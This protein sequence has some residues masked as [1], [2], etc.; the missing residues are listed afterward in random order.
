MMDILGIKRR[1]EA[2]VTVDDSKDRIIQDLFAQL[3]SL[4][5]VLQDTVEHND[6]PYVKEMKRYKTEYDDLRH[7]QAK[8]SF[9]SVLVDGDCMNFNNALIREGYK[10][11]RK[12]ALLLRRSVERHLRDIDPQASPSIQ[13]RIRVYANFPGLTKAYREAKILR[14]NESLDPFIRGFNME[15]SVCDFIDA[16]NGKECSDVKIRASFEQDILDVHCRRIIFCASTDNGYARLLGSHRESNRISLVQGPPF[17]WEMSQ[18]AK[19]FQTTSFPNVFRSTKL[20]VRASSFSAAATRSANK[21]PPPRVSTSPTPSTRST[22]SASSVSTTASSTIYITPPSTPTR[23]YA[24]IA[25][26]NLQTTSPTSPGGSNSPTSVITF[27]ISPSHPTPQ[28]HKIHLNAKNHRIDPTIQSSSKETIHKI[29]AVKFCHKYHIL[30]ECVFGDEC[31]HRHG[32]T[33]S[34]QELMDLRCIAR[35]SPCV[36]GLWCE[37][38]KCISGHQCPWENRQGHDPEACRFPGGLHGV[39]RVV[40]VVL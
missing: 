20:P 27:D 34:G 40:S 25:K 35:R 3:E 19:D 38:E 39:D 9:V 28:F 24:T 21:S 29:H 23:N 5:Q 14:S 13:Y 22:R 17:A 2:M 15:S 16:G 30:G 33:L 26:S 8:L 7:D 18:L 12:A 1:Y 10:G 11:G 36:E 32:P 4:Q 6:V 31:A 37:D